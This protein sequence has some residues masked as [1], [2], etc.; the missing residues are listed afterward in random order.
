[1][2]I[3][4]ISNALG[5]TT[6]TTSF[7][8]T[9]PTTQAGDL[10]IL[11]FAHRGT[12]DGTIAGTYTGP[13]FQLKHSQLFATSLYSGKS[14]W[15]IAT[16]DHAGQTVTGASLTD[17]CAAIVTV[18]RGTD[19]VD[20]LGDA[21]IVGEQNASATKRRPKLQRGLLVLGSFWLL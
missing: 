9:L 18:Y 21:V 11:E 7:S 13:A 3:E 1:M 2:A 15:S 19:D 6:T 17:S 5:G 8:I 10:L 12:G 14:Y 4:Y 20:P 16:G